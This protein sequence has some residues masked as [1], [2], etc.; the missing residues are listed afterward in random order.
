MDLQSLMKNNCNVVMILVIAD[1]LYG[2]VQTGPSGGAQG[3][4][5]IVGLAVQRGWENEKVSRHFLVWR[6]RTSVGGSGSND[7]ARARVFRCAASK[8]FGQLC[9]SGSADRQSH[10]VRTRFK[11]WPPQRM[12]N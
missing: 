5:G 12:A 7:G 10:V 3:N 9:G 1:G 8:E 11:V 2:A 6:K 4:K